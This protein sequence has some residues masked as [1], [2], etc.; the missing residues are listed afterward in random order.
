MLN[1]VNVGRIY[2]SLQTL[3]CP[4]M[5]LVCKFC[6]RDFP[7]SKLSAHE[8]ECGEC[9]REC[10]DCGGGLQVR[11]KDWDK[12]LAQE[13]GIPLLQKSPLM[14]QRKEHS[15]V[16]SASAKRE[17]GVDSSNIDTSSML[18]CEFCEGLISMER[19]LE[20]QVII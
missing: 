20:H 18:P 6:E 2:V 10:E 7:S 11:L 14:R 4:K 12:H 15:A 17:N 16:I 13:H 5:L 19:L 8:S 9:R 1:V 3:L